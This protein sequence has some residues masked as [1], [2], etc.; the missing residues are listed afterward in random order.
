[1][2]FK[3]KNIGIVEEANIE[4]NGITVLTGLNDTGKSFLGKSIYSIIQTINNAGSFLNYERYQ[5]A[6]NLLNGITASHRQF[7]PFTQEKLQQFNVS[8]INNRLGQSIVTRS[9][10]VEGVINEI[11]DYTERVKRDLEIAKGE[12]TAKVIDDAITKI[13]LNTSSLISIL[14]QN[15]DDESKYKAY[16]DR[17][18]VQ[19]IFQSQ[20]NSVLNENELEINIEQGVSNLLKIVVDKNSTKTF[21]VNNDL[22]LNDATLIDTPTIIH[23]TDFITNILAFTPGGKQRG[24]L[25]HYYTDLAE[26]LRTAPLNS[27]ASF[28]DIANKIKKI[29]SGEFTIKSEDGGIVFMKNGNAIRPFNIATG[30][31]SFGLLQLLLNSVY[32]G[33]ASLLIIDEPEVHLHPKWEVEY[34]KIIIELS[35]LGVIILISTHSPYFL[36]ALRKYSKEDEQIEGITK[37]YFGEKTGSN[38][39]KFGDV[40]DNPEPIFRALAE[41][42][43]YL[44]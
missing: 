22:F 13:Q 12:R 30:V 26:K 24:D 5:Y 4:L 27:T 31:K 9:L 6:V 17:V 32:I 40:T 41:P 11:A 35:K 39:T 43:M 16:F 8:P 29:I 15:L 23:L 34:A 28:F 37:F 44:S 25:P 19:K 18:V 20:L 14:E 10:P 21:V 2:I 42:M 7:V 1:M 36:R 33:P 3:F 38:R